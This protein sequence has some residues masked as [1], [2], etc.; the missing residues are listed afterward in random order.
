VPPEF[1]SIADIGGTGWGTASVTGNKITVSN[2][3]TI[4]NTY[5][6]YAFN[7]TAPVKPGLYML[8]VSFSGTPATQAPVGNFSIQVTGSPTNYELDLEEQFVNVDY[9]ETN[10]YLCIYLSSHSGSESIKVDVWYN[11]AWNNV[12]TDLSV[13]WNNVTVSS[14]LTTSTLAIRFKGSIET[15]DTAQDT[16]NIDATLLHL[17]S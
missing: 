16:W 10:E 11:S 13:G 12:L 2:N 8:N 3:Q 5:K 6:T 4:Q 17:W 9:H 14:Y 1:A 15:G 7:A